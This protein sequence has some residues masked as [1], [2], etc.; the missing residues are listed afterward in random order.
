MITRIALKELCR[1][2]R[3]WVG[4]FV[5]VVTATAGVSALFLHIATATILPAEQ[6][7]PIFSIVYGQVAFLLLAAVSTTASNAE[8]AVVET[9]TGYA[10]MQLAGVLPR[11]VK[12]VVVAQ[13]FI[14][15]V[16]GSFLGLVV[17]VIITQ[18]MLD[19]ALAQTSITNPIQIVYGLEPLLWAALITVG[20]VVT[21]GLRAAATA[22]KTPAVL[23]VRSAEIG[24]PRF[25]STGRWIKASIFAAFALLIAVL[26]PA[27]NPDL[28]PKDFRGNLSAIVSL[29]LL[30]GIVL[31]MLCAT[32]SPLLVAGFIR[33]WTAI[34]PQRLSVAWHITRRMICY[35][36]GRSA[37]TL[38]PVLVGIGIPGMLYTVVL[39]ATA[40]F[41]STSPGANNINHGALA[42][43]LAPSL[44]LAALGAVTIVFMSGM[45]RRRSLALLTVSGAAHGIATLIAFIESFIY[46]F[47]ALLLAVLVMAIVGV[48]VAIKLSLASQPATVILGFDTA[49]ITAVIAWLLL[50]L[51]IVPPA[52]WSSRRDLAQTLSKTL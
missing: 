3:V 9:R 23:A 36:K 52:A 50:T 24:N 38:T 7:R 33:L 41:G 48:V 30:F 47:S 22:G 45:S 16:V 34:V 4:T 37:A 44:G 35:G 25:L 43:F 42:I 8:Y 46:V 51:V 11:Q 1:A 20:V 26:I 2:W 13:L 6:G 27:V 49:S 17:G 12:L 15:A 40:E 21:S 5:V 32:I 39:T 28:S 10:R 14:V 18:P 31:L 29:A 19:L